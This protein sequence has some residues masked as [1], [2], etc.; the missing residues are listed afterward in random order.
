MFSRSRGGLLS[1][2]PKG[3]SVCT[4]KECVRERWEVPPSRVLTCPSMPG[5]L[6]A[7]HLEE[8]SSTSQMLSFHA[9]RSMNCGSFA[10]LRV[11]NQVDWTVWKT[12]RWFDTQYREWILSTQPLCKCITCLGVSNEEWKWL[13]MSAFLGI[14]QVY[15]Q[16]FTCSTF[17]WFPQVSVS[18]LFPWAAISS[19]Q[20]PS[21]WSLQHLYTNQRLGLMNSM[22]HNIIPVWFSS[23][24]GAWQTRGNLFESVLGA[25]PVKAAH[26]SPI[27]QAPYFAV[28]VCQHLTALAEKPRMSGSTVGTG[29][30]FL[31][32][33]EWW[34]SAFSHLQ[35]NPAWDRS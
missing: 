22:C 33:A 13:Q 26:D 32:A 27:H 17:A 30:V 16:M 25:P 10:C 19:T 9:A 1:R 21:M 23:Q 24:A 3:S 18:Q 2:V 29:S 12:G 35:F 31:P 34:E 5:Q 14:V 7:L 6:T 15:S 8:A 4:C 11:V 20:G 28:S